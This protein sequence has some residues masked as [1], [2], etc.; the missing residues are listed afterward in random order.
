M[1]KN[2][3][4]ATDVILVAENQKLKLAVE[5]L[6]ILN[7]VATA[8]TSTQSLE[9]VIALMV[10]RCIKHLKV[11]QGAVMILDEQDSSKPF[12]TMIR[13]Q[14]SALEILPYRFDSQLT[15][16]MLKNK[17]PLMVNDLKNDK[18]FNF[19]GEMDLPVKTILSV[20]MSLKGRMIGLLTVFNKK[21]ETGFSA[22]DQRL[23]SI[24][25]A[26]SAHVLENAR[27]N[28]K[29]QD[30]IKMEEEFRMAKEIQLNILPKE[31]PT[32]DRY[33]IHAVNISA[34]EVGG[35]YYDFIKLPGEKLAFCLGDIT[36]KGLP[37]AM[38]MAN[39]QATL[40]GQAFTQ[41]SVK[42]SIKNAN[43][44]LFNSTASN[45]F[46]TVFYGVLNYTNN[47][48]TYC[49]AGHDAPINIKG[50]QINRLNEGGLLLGCFDFAEYEE[51]TKSIDVGESII[52]YSDGVTEAMNAINQ[53]FGEEKFISIVKANQD[54]SG[55]ELIDVILK[56]IKTHSG[57]IAQSDDITLL[58]IKRTV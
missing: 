51:A 28:Q 15:G 27:L 31:I 30:L 2:N 12:Q 53:E 9:K 38:L 10:Q 42:D 33:D 50:D 58:I 48:V 7:D 49:N 3:S 47:S 35:D 40:R 29:E 34:R 41:N 6:S 1:E 57:D 46:A 56:E 20:P 22:D 18:R 23:L 55:K 5:E 54:L 24:I 45:R 52:I 21:S 26:Q 25:A 11:E 17:S 14:D 43:I 8:I 44:L 19:S 39:L 4:P 36:G 32:I 13:K 16:W 37:A